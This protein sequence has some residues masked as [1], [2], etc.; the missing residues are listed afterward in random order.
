MRE[1]RFCCRASSSTP[2][3]NDSKSATEQLE[4]AS[5]AMSKAMYEA[6]QA[7]NAPKPEEPA[8]P[9]SDDDAIDAE[10]EVK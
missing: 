7:A 4:Q 5:H 6:A 8:A 1:M 10:F 9:K 2:F 3:F